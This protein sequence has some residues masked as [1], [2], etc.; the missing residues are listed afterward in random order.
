MNDINIEMSEQLVMSAVDSLNN[1]GFYCLEDVIGSDLQKKFSGE[2]FNL[3]ELKGK[4][5]FSL[6]NPISDK[7]LVFKALGENA[8]L[9]SFLIRVSESALKRKVTITDSL[10]VLRVVTGKNSEGQSLKFHYDAYS[11]TALIPIVIPEGPTKKAGHLVTL[12]I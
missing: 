8:G 1:T 9:N 5:Y 3:L 7:D 11:L 12:R 6:I 4:R 2:V 10:S